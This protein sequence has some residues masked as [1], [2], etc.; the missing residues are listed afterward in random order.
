MPCLHQI[1][2]DNEDICSL[3][4]PLATGLAFCTLCMCDVMRMFLSGRGRTGDVE[5]EGGLVCVL[6]FV[7]ARC[8]ESVSSGRNHSGDVEIEGGLVSVP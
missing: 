5:L 2:S 3:Y 4:H 1:H 7:H 8:D 6:Y